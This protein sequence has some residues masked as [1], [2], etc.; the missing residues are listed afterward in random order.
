M[1]VIDLHDKGLLREAIGE[2]M[3]AL[4]KKDN[5]VVVLNADLMKAS[6][7]KPFVESFPERSFNMSIAEQNMVSFAAGLAHEGFI[8]Y[9][10]SMAPFLSMRACEQVRTDVAYGNL[11]VRL[12]AIYS[13]VSGGISGATHW[14]MEDYGIMRSIPNMTI[15]EPSDIIQAKKL[16]EASLTY[17]G[18]I[19]FRI[20]CE[21]VARI[22]DKDDNFE[23]GKAV[24]LR[25]GKDGAFI[26]SGVTVQYACKAAD[27]ISKSLGI[28][29]SVIDMYSIKPIDKAL[30]IEE[31]KS[32]NIIVAQDHNTAGGLGEAVA[33][34]I[35]H[36]GIN[37]K[38]KCVGIP[39]RFEIMAHSPY[40]YHKFHMDSDGLEK[41]MRK[42]IMGNT[43]FSIVESMTTATD[44]F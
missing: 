10:F 21:P 3:T 31:A 38:I 29:V 19:Y 35:A 24:R 28:E 32:K 8:P 11:N 13:G 12:M 20:S 7:N 16:L 40:L 44:S 1:Q 43:S 34:V 15:V 9:C 33:G 41:E 26:C 4:G 23:I 39:D 42:L 37:C 14:G 17:N 6:R 18:T 22:Y 2:Y 30:I 36:E 25:K 27:R 5:R